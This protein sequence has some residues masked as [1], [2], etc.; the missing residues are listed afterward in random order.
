MSNPRFTKV[1]VVG[2]DGLEPTI[3]EPMQLAGKLPN[4]ARLAARGGYSRVQTTSPAQTPVAWSTFATGVN[5]GAHG[6]F[7][8]VRRNPATYLP[9]LGLN[10]YE[11][12][13]PFVPP[14]VVNLRRGKALWELLAADGIASICLRC[15]CTYPP[16][17]T[18]G[19]MLSG[20]GVPDLRGGFGTATFYTTAADEAS[21]EGEQVILID[22]KQNRRLTTYLPGPLDRKT[23]LPHRL[24]LIIEPKPGSRQAVLHTQGCRE[25]L[26]I[27]EGKWSPWLRVRFKLGMLQSVAGIVRF[28]LVRLRPSVELYASPINFDAKEPLFPISFPAD[29]AG[30]LAD[31]IGTYYT[32]GMAEDHAGLNNGRFS[33]AAFLDQCASLWQEREKMMLFELDRFREGFFYCLY[34]TPD[35]VQHMFWRFREADHPANRGRPAPAA[36]REVVEEHY[37]IAD[38]IVGKA[39]EH[40]AERTLLIVL[41]DHGFKSFQRGVNLNTWLHR[42]GFLM[43][44]KGTRPGQDA[45][46]LLQTVDWSC[47]RAY[48]T[49][50]TGIYLNLK[51]RE[52]D[53]IVPP[54]EA[55]ELKR[56]IAA[57]LSGLADPARGQVAING[58]LPRERVYR[59]PYVEEAPDLLVNFVPPYRTSWSTALGG[60]PEQ[61]FEDN[62]RCWSGDHMVDPTLVPGVLWMNHP[63]RQGARLLDLAPTILK[64]LG[65]KPSPE[66]EGEPLLL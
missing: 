54:D 55:D 32:A 22:S 4:L 34:D 58:V 66:M 51:G 42:Q 49:G 26:T 15:P 52:R 63:F 53:G 19:R 21:Q 36:Y 6:I 23:R 60:V 18:R 30:Q 31:K 48:A 16:D 50:L 57:Q 24:E 65:S 46:D 41:S 38:T 33:E 59:G 7:D 5:P 25:A 17:M 11:Q 62:T 12:K 37:R 13:N 28:Y 35:R 43:L 39:M 14:R 20:L 40:A 10:R 9:D 64:A 3:A 56:A 44:K 2:L 45:G 27:E 8:F 1:V 61:E 47:T 29:Y